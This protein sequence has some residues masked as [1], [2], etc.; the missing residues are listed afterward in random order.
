GLLLVEKAFIFEVISQLAQTNE[1]LPRDVG[2]FLARRHVGAAVEGR[3]MKKQ[4][5]QSGNAAA[6]EKQADAAPEKQSP[7]PH[8]APRSTEFVAIKKAGRDY[9]R[10]AKAGQGYFGRRGHSQSGAV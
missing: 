4:H 3:L 9:S 2:A 10:G 7:S 8:V 1:G 5:Q 6:Y